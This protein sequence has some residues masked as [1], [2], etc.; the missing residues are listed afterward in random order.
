MKPLDSIVECLEKAQCNL[1]CIIGGNPMPIV[2]W[3]KNKTTLTENDNIIFE[4]NQDDGIYKCLIKSCEMIDAGTY[5]V[6]AKNAVGEVTSTSQLSIVTI[7]KVIKNL[8]LSGTNPSVLKNKSNENIIYL[9]E[10][11]SLKL[12][13]Q[14]QGTPKPII[15]GF[16]NDV[17]IKQDD[18]IKL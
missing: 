10:K 8:V 18:R 4:V 14:I 2:S 7:P 11:S 3:F 15:K 17:E 12:D 9:I 16:K 13:C 1:E 6:K 5:V